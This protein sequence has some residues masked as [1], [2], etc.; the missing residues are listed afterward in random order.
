M[1][2]I[3]A[4]EVTGE[5]GEPTGIWRRCAYWSE[6]LPEMLRVEL[7]RHDHRSPAE[8]QAC[9]EARE[10]ARTIWTEE[11][12]L[13]HNQEGVTPYDDSAKRPVPLTASR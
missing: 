6:H 4:F 12:L 5:A 1:I 10:F 9:I 11:A 8:A 3:R 13:K 7:C 2:C